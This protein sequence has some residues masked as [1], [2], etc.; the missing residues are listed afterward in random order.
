MATIYLVGG[1][2]YTE[3]RLIREGVLVVEEGRITRLGPGNKVRPSSEAET[4]DVRGLAVVP[5]LIDLHLHGLSGFDVMAAEV[6]GI[7]AVLPRY[8][9]TSF[10]P[11]TVPATLDEL[12]GALQKIALVKR[13]NPSGAR[14]LGI[15][16]EGPFL[17]PRQAGVMNAAYVRPFDHGEFQRLT[18]AA[19]GEVKIVT[20]APEEGQA[21]ACLPKLREQGVIVAVGHSSA[22][23]E[24][25]REAVEA[26][27]SY[28]THTFNAMG[29][30]HHREPGTAGA[31]LYFQEITTEVIADG[32][33]LHSAVLD[34]ILRMK[35]VDGVVLVSD[36][37]PLAGLPPGH[38]SWLGREVE[39]ETDRVATADGQLAGSASTVNNGLRTLVRTL[40]LS[41]QRAI[42]PASLVP[43]R[44]LGLEHQLGRLKE[45]LEADIAVFDEDFKCR[46]CLVRGEVVHRDL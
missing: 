40:E 31:A 35:G 4:I 29:P 42:R 37:S 3:N 17:S 6:D 2:I 12:S 23:F 8:G 22:T 5:G 11:T 18:A 30:L 14:I 46:C 10:L 24:E 13:G 33:H 7:A 16:M 43:A 15:H 45:G 1:D 19:G 36:A 32:Q 39:V 25:V 20:L 34:L 38:Y 44:V 28:S 41:L 26:G 21:T 9:V 27:L